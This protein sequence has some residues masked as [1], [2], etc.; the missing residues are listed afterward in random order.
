M[1]EERKVITLDGVQ[2]YIDSIPEDAT[3]ILNGIIT[4]NTELAQLERSALIANI[5]RE[6]LSAKLAPM[7]EKFEKV[8]ETK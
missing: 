7:L 2:Y 1:A 8:P 6:S 3:Q 5:A 4:V